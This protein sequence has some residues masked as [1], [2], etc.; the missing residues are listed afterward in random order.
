MHR[1]W[2]LPQDET[3]KSR[4]HSWMQTWG[5]CMW[6]HIAFVGPWFKV[7]TAEFPLL[8]HGSRADPVLLLLNRCC[9]ERLGKGFFKANVASAR[10]PTGANLWLR[11][12]S[13][14][15]TDPG[16]FAFYWACTWP[17]VVWLGVTSLLLSG[18]W[19]CQRN[20]D[21]I[22]IC[23]VIIFKCFLAEWPSGNSCVSKSVWAA[24]TQ[25]LFRQCIFCLA[26]FIGCASFDVPC[27]W[28]DG[29][30][31]A[32]GCRYLSNC[33][34]TDSWSDTSSHKRGTGCCHFSHA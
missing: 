25:G 12:R 32:K 2:S 3:R 16:L 24:A 19:Y 22:W 26:G 33:P 21:R 6:N 13:L 31:T 20:L 1:T 17:C 11:A 7:E 5:I 34:F 23:F 18:V 9:P 15:H 10:T 27:A 30:S 8:W 28:T 4:L 29:G 14:L